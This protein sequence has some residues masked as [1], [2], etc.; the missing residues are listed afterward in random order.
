M[1][2]AS[3][4]GKGEGELKKMPMK[5]ILKGIYKLDGVAPLQYGL[6]CAKS[7]SQKWGQGSW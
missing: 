7:I 5:H 1:S 2:S 3:L 4:G 6:M